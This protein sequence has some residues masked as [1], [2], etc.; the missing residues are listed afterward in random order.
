MTLVDDETLAQLRQGSEL[1][2]AAAARDAARERDTE[3]AAAIDDGRIPVSRREHYVRMWDGDPEGT[4]SLL[5]AL[6]P[7]LV[8]VGQREI[9]RTGDGDD[10]DAEEAYPADWL[11]E[12]AAR[13]TDPSTAPRGARIVMEG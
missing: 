8:P 4:R 12:V 5:A 1:A 11:P 7:G 13:G 6:T 9:G 3:I 2:I 10:P